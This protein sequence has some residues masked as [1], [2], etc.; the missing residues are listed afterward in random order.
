MKFVAHINVMPHKVLLDPQGKAVGSGLK[1]LGMNEIDNVRVG[2]H[3][4]L[5]VEA[6]S[7]DSAR[8]KVNEAC[9]KL[10]ANKVMEYFEFELTQ[11]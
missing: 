1:N 7:E 3:I 5:E 10:L 9:E 2:K 11:E 4:T 6:E 8:E